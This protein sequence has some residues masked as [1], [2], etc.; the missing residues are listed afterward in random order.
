MRLNSYKFSDKNVDDIKTQ[1]QDDNISWKKK[2][3]YKSM[4]HKESANFPF[5]ISSHA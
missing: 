5:E 2:H 3:F 1:I 4:Q